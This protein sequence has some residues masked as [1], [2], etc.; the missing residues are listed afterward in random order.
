MRTIDLPGAPPP[1][2][3]YSP[4]IAHEG[5]LYVS[6]QLPID[7]QDQSIPPT[8]EAQTDLV[9]AKLERILTAAGTAK[10]RVIQVRIYLADI[11]LW[12]RVNVRY[13][14]FFGDHRPVRCV[15]P[16]GPLHYGCGIELEALAAVERE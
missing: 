16:T 7:P 4:A 6:G 10:D 13:A 2:G 15:V 11:E 3:H 9:L 5:V 14:A 1:K 8:I 12:D